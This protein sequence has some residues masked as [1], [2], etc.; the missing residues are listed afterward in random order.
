MLTEEVAQLS[1]EVERQRL[2]LS[3]G[4]VDDLLTSV[5]AL[6]EQD[7]AQRDRLAALR[8]EGQAQQDRLAA[9]EAEFTQAASE[10]AA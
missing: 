2:R 7:Q 4:N 9:R 6:R 10:R 5:A 1:A 3:E 8:E